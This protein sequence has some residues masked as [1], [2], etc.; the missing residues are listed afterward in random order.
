M[1]ATIHYKSGFPSAQT[2][3]ETTAR[4]A[5]DGLITGSA[6]FV[7]AAGAQSYQVNSAITP[8]IFPGLAGVRLGGLYVESRQ[9]EKRGGIYTL[10]LGVVGALASPVV[11]RK[12]DVF[13]RSASK[14]ATINDEVVTA[15]FDY[16]SE[17]TTASV[18]TA[19][20]RT[21]EPTPETPRPVDRWNVRGS[22][23]AIL[24][25]GVS[26]EVAGGSSAVDRV[27]F[28]G[29][30]LTNTSREERAGIVRIIKTSQFVYE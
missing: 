23:I 16:S 17:T 18:V 19:G 6:V 13:P 5:D 3:V 12:K 20:S 25:A 14:T 10:T 4:I 8:A 15:S 29:R 26:G 27:V 1:P 11:L 24:N 2:P 7:V 21:Q 30:I 28:Y 22:K 9:L